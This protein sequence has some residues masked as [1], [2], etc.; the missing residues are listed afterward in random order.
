[1]IGAGGT[2]GRSGLARKLLERGREPFVHL[3][4]QVPRGDGDHAAADAALRGAKR[5]ILEMALP[6]V[7]AEFRSS[8]LERNVVNA[9]VLRA[10]QRA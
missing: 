10:T 7:P 4:G 8:F 9:W 6:N 2:G 3:A 5:W 1:M